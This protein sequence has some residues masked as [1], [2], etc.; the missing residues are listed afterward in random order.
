MSSLPLVADHLSQEAKSRCA[1]Q[2]DE[3]DAFGRAAFNRYYYATFLSTRQL[4]MQVESSWSESQ[5]STIP[6]L[7]EK[8]L[9]KKLRAA[10]K[11]LRKK[12]VIAEGKAE[13]LLRQVGAA[14]GDTAS[15]LRMANNVRITADYRPEEKIVFEASTFKLATHTEAEAKE[16]LPRIER[17]NGVILKVAREIGLV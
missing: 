11:P 14:A 13:S 2:A 1:N 15:I 5:H 16:W 4:L 3:A 8:S 12:K 9:V 6:N 10:L 17:N 7:L